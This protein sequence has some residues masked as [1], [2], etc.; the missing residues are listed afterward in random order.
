MMRGITR[1]HTSITG[2][3]VASLAVLVAPAAAQS[4]SGSDRLPPLMDEAAEI[5]LARSAAPPSISGDA[6]VWVLRRGGHVKARSG[7]SG[8]ACIV[9]RDHPE[10]LY[11]ICYD[12][13]GARTILRIAIRQQQLREQ[14]LSSDQ[15]AAEIEAALER[16]ELSAPER[17]AIAWM[18]SAEQVIFN[19]ADGPRV[20]AWQ[21]H[22]MVYVP[23]A[24][25]ESTGVTP[26]ADGD[27]MIRNAGTATAHFIMISRDWAQR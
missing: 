23:Y 10:S 18:Q 15:V 20:G 27:F 24:T 25:T 16:G 19:G 5:R 9:Q 4:G 12:A 22:V 14:G 6:D 21:P 3:L 8:V 17:S 1:S 13:E 2:T 11:P 26:L 7:S